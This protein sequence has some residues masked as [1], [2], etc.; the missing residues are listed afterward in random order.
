MI[1]TE[2]RELSGAWGLVED[3][4]LHEVKRWM[5]KLMGLPTCEE[6]ADWAYA[7]LEGQL[8]PEI[9]ARFQKHLR[10]CANCHRFIESYRKVA[11]PDGLARS[12]P[13][14][15]EFEKRTLEFLKEHL[16]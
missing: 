7:F 10:G 3:L 2:A 5:M 1:E 15:P 11:R 9:E 14:D 16:R 4:V 6:V 8:E 12:I 13:L